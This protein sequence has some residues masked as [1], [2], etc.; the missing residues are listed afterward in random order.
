MWKQK[1]APHGYRFQDLGAEK[2][3]SKAELAALNRD[4]S[5][6]AHIKKQ[7]PD[8]KIIDVCHADTKNTKF[9]ISLEKPKILGPTINSMQYVI[10][11]KFYPDTVYFIYHTKEKKWYVFNSGDVY[12]GIWD[13]R[14]IPAKEE[15]KFTIKHIN[16]HLP[17]F[18]PPSE[19]KPSTYW[20][21]SNQNYL[22]L[23]ISKIKLREDWMSLLNT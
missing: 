20:E 15:N 18:N 6:E 3:Y 2:T 11:N 16:E 4:N 7:R 23:D 5:I 12:P 21:A 19:R 13:S 10:F 22:C 8:T 17:A 14:Y 1:L 9:V